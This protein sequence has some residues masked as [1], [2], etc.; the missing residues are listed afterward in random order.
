M[1]QSDTYLARIKAIAA[2]GFDLNEL[3]P[4]REELS[5]DLSAD[6]HAAVMWALTE[7]DDPTTIWWM[8]FVAQQAEIL[9]ALPVLREKLPTLPRRE[10]LRDYRD[11]IRDSIHHLASL[12][13]GRCACATAQGS[14]EARP[15]MRIDRRVVHQKQYYSTLYVHCHRCGKRYEVDEDPSY[16]F[17]TYQWRSTPGHGPWPDP[18]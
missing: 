9:E 16:H 5:A 1:S 4:L 18:T 8:A 15:E 2:G 7:T 13:E 17:T 10:G 12:T 11:S 14:P 3:G 6:T